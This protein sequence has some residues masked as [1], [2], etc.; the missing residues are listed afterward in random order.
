MGDA[1]AA[2]GA[3]PCT[4]SAHALSPEHLKFVFA[5]YLRFIQPFNKNNQL[6]ITQPDPFKV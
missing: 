5:S 3:V 4:S 1:A 2:S 6:V